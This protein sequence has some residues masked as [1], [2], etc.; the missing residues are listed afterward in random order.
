MGPCQHLESFLM[1]CGVGKVLLLLGLLV[2]ASVSGLRAGEF[3]TAFRKQVS[4]FVSSLD[5]KQRDA[6]LYD[7]DDQGRWRMQYT[8]GKRPGIKISQLDE[9]QRA[10]MEKALRLV[11]SPH[12][13]KMANDVARQDAHQGGDGGDA[14][15]KYWI[16]C[17]GD[18]RKG[19]FAF[20]L[21]EHHLTVVQLELAKGEASEFGPIL[22]GSNP[23]SLWRADEQALMDVWKLIDDDKV[24]LKGQ[25]AVAGEAMPAAE[26]VV[27][28]KLN[29]VAQKALKEAWARRLSI[30][31]DPIQQRINS[32]H[33]QR[34][35]WGKSRVAYYHE[36]PAKRCID[37]GRWDFKCGLPGMVWDFESSRGHIHMSLWVKGGKD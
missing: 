14:L 37:G 25:K 16:T 29:T 26:G 15:G 7:I 9:K 32:L 34:G 19:D 17:F 36:V 2:L 10:T 23:P 31:T 22:L 18:P 11:L 28:F 3:E 24:L 33:E 35:G 1:K 13:W 5:E 8:G 12:G 30:F 27:F 20:R 21:A 4:A 6:C